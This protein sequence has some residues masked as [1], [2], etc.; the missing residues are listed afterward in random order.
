MVPSAA[1]AAARRATGTRYGEQRH[2]VQASAVAELDGRRIAAVLAADADF[3]VGPGLAAFA[4]GHLASAGP[5]RR[6]PAPGTGS[7]AGSCLRRSA[8]GTCPRRRRGCSRTSSASGRWCRT[9]RTAAYSAIC[10]AVSAP[11]GT[12]IIVPNLYSISTPCSSMTFLAT[13]SRV[14][15]LILQLV[16]V[17]DERDH[18]LGLDHDALLGHDCTPPRRSRAPASR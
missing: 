9:R 13:A 7:P 6:G 17:A 5:R 10:P 16:D 2:I 1:C 11:R 15:W 12:S 18:D 3:Q 4:H 8:A 14:V